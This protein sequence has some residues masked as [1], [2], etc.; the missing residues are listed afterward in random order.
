MESIGGMYMRKLSV[1]LLSFFYIFF[2]CA[3]ARAQSGK[4]AVLETDPELFAIIVGVANWEV[5]NGYRMEGFLRTDLNGDG[6]TDAIV[7][8]ENPSD[9]VRTIAIV[10]SDPDG[11]HVVQGEQAMPLGAI[12][13]GVFAGINAGADYIALYTQGLHHECFQNEYLFSRNGSQFSLSK[14]TSIQWRLESPD[15]TKSTFDFTNGEY[16]QKNGTMGNDGFSATSEAKYDLPDHMHPE[17]LA[18][19]MPVTWNELAAG[20]SAD[21]QARDPAESIFCNACEQYFPTGDAFR[22]HWCAA[23]PQRMEP[24][25]CTACDKTFESYN[26]LQHHICIPHGSEKI[27]CGICG[28]SFSN[29]ESYQNHICISYLDSNSVYCDLC[30]GWYAEGEVFRSH[31]CVP[32]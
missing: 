32:E 24:L 3:P 12:D 26:A 30:D 16:I 1:V 27:A 9:H 25:V 23:E 8:L 28:H 7:L 17:S 10:M 31:L 21:N 5:P 22:N 15:A 4:A 13:A 19:N 11:Y 14:I 29:D 6:I 18:Y 20:A 2:L